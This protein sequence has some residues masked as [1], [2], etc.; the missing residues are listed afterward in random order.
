M[1]AVRLSQLPCRPA[2]IHLLLFQIQ[3]LEKDLM[4]KSKRDNPIVLLAGSGAAEKQLAPGLWLSRRS[5]L[6]WCSAGLATQAFLAAADVIA[7]EPSLEFGD[8]LQ[9]A[10]AAARKLLD[11]SSVSGQDRYLRTISAHAAGLR[12][13]PLPDQWNDSGQSD[14]PG[15]FIGFNP[16]GIGFV[17][18]HWR[19][20]PGT[21]ILPHAHTYGNVVTVGLEGVVRV[22]NY[23][24][25]GKR[26]YTTESDFVVRNTVDQA[27]RVGATN[28][29][30]LERNYIHGFDAGNEGGRGLDIT[31]RLLP[32]PD[33]DVPYLDIREP[34]D[35][36]TA[37]HHF[38]ARWRRSPVASH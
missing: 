30:S 29:V 12:D 6:A 4:H 15:T 37:E 17:V 27:L 11:D 24:V 9:A 16:G 32:K 23:E 19:M 28:L 18:L 20:E 2:V 22:R 36:D 13:V 8:F 3:G 38:V 14:G 31:T 7:A 34:L 1:R 10:N 33:F 25:V 35:S 21:R 26:D 5:F